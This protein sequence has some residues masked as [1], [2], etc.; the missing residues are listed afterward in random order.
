MNPIEPSARQQSHI[1]ANALSL[2]AFTILSL[3]PLLQAKAQDSSQPSTVQFATVQLP[4][5]VVLVRRQAVVS[6]PREHASTEDSS[7]SPAPLDQV[8]WGL[9]ISAET[10]RVIVPA[11][12]LENQREIKLIVSSPHTAH[13][14]LLHP[15]EPLIVD[16]WGDWAVLEPIRSSTQ[17]APDFAAA[18][19]ASPQISGEPYALETAVAALPHPVTWLQSASEPPLVEAIWEPRWQGAGQLSD[20]A[21][22][23]GD[24]W[25]DFG[26]L[27]SLRV[28]KSAW[29]GPLFNA[30]KQCV[31]WLTPW[32]P[33]QPLPLA[34]LPTENPEQ[35][36]VA[37]AVGLDESLSRLWQQLDQGSEPTFGF[38]GI[39]PRAT[40]QSVRDRGF[41]G[42]SVYDVAAATPAARLGLGYGDLI[43]HWNGRP[44]ETPETLLWLIAA[45]PPGAETKVRWVRGVLTDQP[46][47]FEETVV[48]SRRPRSSRWPITRSIQAPMEKALVVDWATSAPDFSLA[49]D[50]LPPEGG[51][52]IERV[53]ESLQRDFPR[54]TPGVWIVQVNDQAPESPDQFWSFV[55]QSSAD[56]KLSIWAQGEEEPETISVPRERLFESPEVP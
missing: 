42:V 37:W 2:I 38:L 32:V 29:H 8:H 43:T 26:G 22:D 15:Y 56:L 3:V 20:G 23:D 27:Q 28:S 55:Q 53:S 47:E 35:T 25:I 11:H 30:Q 9:V 36:Q 40:R 19:L 44:V 6:S 4:P 52:W 16:P 18:Q 31:G 10:Q 34:T 7:A 51:V 1:F 21:I 41:T 33:S 45:F 12:L 50:D 14:G 17:P 48:V 13:P 46:K 24:R 39:R 49:A 54:L 5:G